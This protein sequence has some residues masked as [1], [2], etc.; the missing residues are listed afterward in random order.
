MGSGRFVGGFEGTRGAVKEPSGS[1]I[2]RGSQMAGG[3][4]GWLGPTLTAGGGGGDCIPGIVLFDQT[5][6]AEETVISN[7]GFQAYDVVTIPFDTY[8]TPCQLKITI[9]LDAHD[10]G[11]AFDDGELDAYVAPP[12][13]VGGG[14]NSI[15]PASFLLFHLL[16]AGPVYTTY[17]LMNQIGTTPYVIFDNPGVPLSIYMWPPPL[18]PGFDGSVIQLRNVHIV[19]ETV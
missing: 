19:V 16:T 10:I 7:G 17:T 4:E 12:G 6:P 8:D 14:F 1:S 11:G 3:V 13:L 18:F 15:P 5:F 2:Q 9:T